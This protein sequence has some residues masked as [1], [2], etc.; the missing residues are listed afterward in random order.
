MTPILPLT[1]M[2]QD[3]MKEAARIA[4]VKIMSYYKGDQPGDGNLPGLLH[5]LTI[6]KSIA[7]TNT[8]QALL[9]QKGENKDYMPR[10]QKASLGNDDQCFWAL[11]A[12]NAVEYN[13]PDSDDP[14]EASWLSLAQAVFNEQVLRWN[15]ETCGGGIHWQI[16]ERNGYSLKN[17]ISNGCFF[18]LAARLGRYSKDQ[19]YLDW[20]TKAWDWMWAVNLID[21]NWSVYDNVEALVLNCT[22]QE[23][24]QWTYNAGTLMVGAATMYNYTGDVC[25]EKDVCDEDQKSFKA[26][27]AAWMGR[28]MLMAPWTYDKIMPF[29]K[30]SAVAAAKQCS[31]GSDGTTCGMRWYW[32]ETWDANS[33]VGQQMTAMEV[34]LNTMI[35]SVEQEQTPLVPLTNFTGGTS[36]SDPTAGDTGGVE[37]IR[38]PFIHRSTTAGRAGAW[39]LTVVLCLS[40]VAAIKEKRKSAFVL[41]GI[42][43]GKLMKGRGEKTVETEERELGSQEN[44]PELPRRTV[45]KLN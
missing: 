2:T 10:L 12:M 25:E 24:I 37:D 44:G 34:F 7:T 14:E 9:Y 11:A 18:Q 27:L 35:P 31:G 20:A 4:A 3:S 32:N 33:G 39:I 30:S 41:P 15:T 5:S 1:L 36:K 38:S 26:Y 42:R 28:T 21:K 6:G 40:T 45:I 29:L 16:Y 43:K 23:R 22:Q 8:K 13:F 19:L 17:T